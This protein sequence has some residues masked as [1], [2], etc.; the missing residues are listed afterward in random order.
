MA[1]TDIMHN[2]VLGTAQR[3]IGSVLRELCQEGRYK[4]VRRVTAQA[5][6]L[7]R[8]RRKFKSWLKRHHVV[9][10]VPIFTPASMTWNGHEYPDMKGKHNTRVV[11]AWLHK[12]TAEQAAQTPSTAANMRAACTWSLARLCWELDNLPDR[13]DNPE[14]LADVGRHFLTTYYWLAKEALREGKHLYAVIPKIHLRV[15]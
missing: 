13:L 7:L 1:K 8:A 4:G 14:R 3:L 5:Y 10:S 6:S 15:P 12:E 11:W 9:C 2:L